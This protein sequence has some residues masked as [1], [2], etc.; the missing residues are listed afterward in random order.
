MLT[1]RWWGELRTAPRL[2]YNNDTNMKVE[3]GHINL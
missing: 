2:E 1:A 3:G